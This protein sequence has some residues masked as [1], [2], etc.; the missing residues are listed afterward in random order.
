MLYLSTSVKS[1][2][3]NARNGIMFVNNGGSFALSA[4]QDNLLE[5]LGRRNDRDLLEVVL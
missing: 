1:N 4:R 3:A 2:L 5:I